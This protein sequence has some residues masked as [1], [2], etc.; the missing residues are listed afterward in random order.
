M[1]L[2]S[3]QFDKLLQ[4]VNIDKYEAE[5]RTILLFVANSDVDSVCAVKQL[6]VFHG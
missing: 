5:D 1:L 6:Q 4:A 3:K 2:D